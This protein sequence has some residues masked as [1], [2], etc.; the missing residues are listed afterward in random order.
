MAPQAVRSADGV[1]ASP[2]GGSKQAEKEYLSKAG[3]E[4]WERIKPFSSPGHDDI[5]EGA[6]LIHDFAVALTCLDAR[7][8]H[9]VLDLGA[10]GCWA[11]EWLRRFNLRTISIDIATDMLRVGRSRLDTEAWLAAGDL[12]RLP[13]AASSVDGA[14][15]LNA[16][17]HVPDA[18]AALR[19]VH[20]VLRPGTHV[21]FSEP[22]RG[23]AAA[24]VSRTAAGDFGV[25][26][27]DVLAGDLLAGCR[28]AG[29]SRAVLKPVAHL[30]PWYEIDADRWHRW[31]RHAAARRPLR[32]AGRV[33][34]A[35]LEGLGIAKQ[36][37]AFEDALGMEL[38][39]ILQGA[40]DA[41]PIVVATK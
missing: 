39:R 18:P 17:H 19:E 15:C 14:V 13:L 25:Q 16:F 34:R 5:A 8:G 7:P 24:E 6:R 41:H 29:F 9:L 35:V 31:Q 21:V 1:D 33:Y 28:T 27:R 3:T 38:I 26:E 36:G 32:A 37:A 11:S 40:M 2:A 22:G 10:G 20:R 23:H 30:V 12:E 4:R